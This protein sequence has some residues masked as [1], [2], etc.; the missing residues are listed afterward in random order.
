MAGVSRY[1]GI[2][3][4]RKDRKYL[5]TILSA[6]DNVEHIALEFS[7]G[8]YKSMRDSIKDY[9]LSLTDEEITE[10]RYIIKA[11]GGVDNMALRV[12]YTFPLPFGSLQSIIKEETY[13]GCGYMESTHVVKILSEIM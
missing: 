2:E 12:F 10:L 7:W 1:V 4:F 9:I 8:I 13:C 11:N 6:D 5:C 3:L